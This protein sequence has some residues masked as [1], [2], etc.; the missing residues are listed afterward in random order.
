MRASLPSRALTI[1]ALVS[2]ALW[3]GGMIALGAIVA[4]VIFGT[5]P[6][7]LSA[8]AMTVVFRRFDKVAVACAVTLLLTEVGQAIVRKPLLR[9]DI[10]RA[11]LSVVGAAL[12]META[13]S[14]SPKI[15]A[16]HRAGAIRGLGDLGMQLQTTHN[17]A[18][19]C[20][21][22]QAIVAIVLIGIHVFGLSESQKSARIAPEAETRAGTQ[23]G[24]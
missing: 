8:D 3:M 15:E 17:L 7:P 16:L 4:P 24:T 11:A 23:A 14:I 10:A 13:L 19:L 5:V 22:A 21:K 6:S 9:I 18:E 1:V 2:I 12:V 20:G